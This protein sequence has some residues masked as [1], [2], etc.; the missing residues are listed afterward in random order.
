MKVKKDSKGQINED[1][2][3]HIREFGLYPAGKNKLSD[4]DEMK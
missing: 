3:C 2:V 4:F 1:F